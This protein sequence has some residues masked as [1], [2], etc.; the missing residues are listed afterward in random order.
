MNYTVLWRRFAE[1]LLA[2]LWRTAPDRNA[3]AAAADRIDQL[4]QRD[5]LD[6]GESR[7]EESLRILCE[8]PLAVDYEVD[9]ENRVVSVLRVWRFRRP[10]PGDV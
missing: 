9:V 3:V 2:D 4:L 1:N 6:L 7:D 8:P 5:P 10:A